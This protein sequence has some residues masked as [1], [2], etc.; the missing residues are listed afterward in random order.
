MNMDGLDILDS[1]IR[2]FMSTSSLTLLQTEGA[3]TDRLLLRSSVCRFEDI[4]NCL[5]QLPTIVTTV[6]MSFYSHRCCVS[7]C[8]SLQYLSDVF[9]ARAQCLFGQPV[10]KINDVLGP[11][12]S[13][14]YFCTSRRVRSERLGGSGGGSDG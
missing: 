8:N 9:Y 2:C 4:G 7:L 6:K 5:T 1:E 13:D 12:A 3:L 11:N 10:A 14:I